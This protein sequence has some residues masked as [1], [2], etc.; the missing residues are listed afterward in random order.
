MNFRL[1]ANTTS[2]VL[3][4]EAGF[5]LLPLLVSVLYGEPWMPFFATAVLCILIGFILQLVPVKKAQMHSRDGF[6]AVALGWIA[7]SLTGALPYVF[8]GALNNY[9]DPLSNF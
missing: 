2:Y 1:I 9:V 8:S 6:M 5:L 7:L 4:V 3:W